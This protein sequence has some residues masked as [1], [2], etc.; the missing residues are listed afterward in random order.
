[1]EA[2]KNKKLGIHEA[3][4][5][6]F[7]IAVRESRARAKLCEQYAAV[8]DELATTEE[9]FGKNIVKVAIK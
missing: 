3:P 7:R 8:L 6:F 9:V 1:M 2:P 4:A 5:T